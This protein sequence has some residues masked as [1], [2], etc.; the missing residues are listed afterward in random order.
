MK[1][2]YIFVAAINNH[3]KHYFILK[4]QLFKKIQSEL[5]DRLSKNEWIFHEKDAKSWKR[6]PN[7]SKFRHENQFFDYDGLLQKTY[8]YFDVSDFNNLSF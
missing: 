1:S 3:I 4:L 6:K 7:F 5:T 2:Y 8:I